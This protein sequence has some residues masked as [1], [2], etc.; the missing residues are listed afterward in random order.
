[1]VSQWQEIAQSRIEG[2]AHPAPGRCDGDHSAEAFAD[3]GLALFEKIT[4]QV[5]LDL[6]EDPLASLPST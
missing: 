1:M 5:T 6:L 4:F 2:R 3:A